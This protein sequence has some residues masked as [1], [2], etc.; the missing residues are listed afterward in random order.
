M[1]M[2]FASERGH[3]VAASNVTPMA[4]VMIRLLIIFMVMT[5][6]FGHD[7]HV[8]LP[9][10]RHGLDLRRDGEVSVRIRDDGS[11]LLGERPVGTLAQLSS[12][13][14]DDPV[15]S[16]ESPRLL[17]VAADASLP[18]SRVARVLDAC[19]AAGIDELL[20]VTSPRERGP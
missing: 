6:M 19:R 18:Y 14:R 2:S 5:P 17:R 1:A 4:D 8:R 10:A 16:S 9:A 15:L 11:V 13:L 3:L 20:L 12:E 7:D